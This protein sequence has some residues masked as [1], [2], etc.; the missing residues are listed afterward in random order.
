MKP[1]E[2]R[3]FVKEDFPEAPWMEKLLRPLNTLLGQVRAG[4]ANGLTLGEN[5]NAEVKTV[6]V[7]GVASVKFKTRV[8]SAAGVVLLRAVELSGRDQLPVSGVG[9]VNWAQ[10]AETVTISS[11]TGLATGHTYRLTVAVLGG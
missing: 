9:G 11:V 6:D 8:K 10:S 7:Q 1:F 2:F 4:L 5:L 3:N